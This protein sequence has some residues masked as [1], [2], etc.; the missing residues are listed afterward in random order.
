MGP[1]TAVQAPASFRLDEL[2]TPPTAAPED[3]VRL[4]RRALAKARLATIPK[5][6]PVAALPAILRHTVLKGRQTM[7]QQQAIVAIITAGHWLMTRKLHNEATLLLA[8]STP[9]RVC[10][11]AEIAVLRCRALVRLGRR[12]DAVAE[13]DRLLALRPGNEARDRALVA[14]LKTHLLHDQLRAHWALHDL[15]WGAPGGTVVETLESLDLSTY[16][17]A[18]DDPLLHYL[19]KVRGQP[20]ADQDA[21]RDA[22]AWGLAANH[23]R[24]FISRSFQEKRRRERGAGDPGPSAA[25]LKSCRQITEARPNR[26]LARLVAEGRAV[27]LLQ[28]HC[29]VRG[30]VSQSLAELA[31]PLSLVG[32][33]ERLVRQRT[34]DFNISTSTPADLPLQFLKLAK[35]ARQGPRVIRLLPD[36]G[37]GSAFADIDLFGRKVQIGLGG[38]LLAQQG[39]AVLAFARTR[40]TGAGWA[41]EVD[42]GPDLAGVTDRAEAEALFADFYAASLRG[43]LRGPARD[44]GGTGGF[45]GKLRKEIA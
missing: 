21:L 1:M 3:Q 43:I 11:L 13:A 22:L 31:C 19:L 39:K 23:Y 38:A 15:I 17:R 6:N 10:D 14:F 35:L 16:R 5:R 9:G 41:V 33:V 2:F 28:S 29:G 32:R 18:F 24:K 36:G 42:I 20:E 37:D 30:V 8:Q 44:I 34:G 7:P 25:Y 26:T 27:V 40:W 12:D 45:L 4:I